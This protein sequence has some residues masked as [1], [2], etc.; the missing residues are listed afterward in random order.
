MTPVLDNLPRPGL[1]PL[2]RLLSDG[3]RLRILA[4]LGAGERNVT[5]VCERLALRQPTASH[6]LALLRQGGLAVCRRAGKNVFYGPGPGVTAG[7]D[8][9]WITAGGVSVRIAGV[10]LEPSPAVAR[11]V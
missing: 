6:H 8:G 9:L 11:A 7:S 4:L 10:Q 3:T 5:D 2:F 1:L